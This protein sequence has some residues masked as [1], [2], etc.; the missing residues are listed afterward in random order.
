MGEDSPHA[1]LRSGLVHNAGLA[2][3]G[4]DSGTA[5][6]AARESDPNQVH[7]PREDGKLAAAAFGERTM[8]PTESRIFVDADAVTG[9]S[10]GKA[11]HQAADVGLPQRK[12]LRV[13]EGCARQVTEGSATGQTPVSLPAGEAPPSVEAM[14]SAAR[15]SGVAAAESGSADDGEQLA[16]ALPRT[17]PQSH[18]PEDTL[19]RDRIFRPAGGARPSRPAFLDATVLPTLWGA[20]VLMVHGRKV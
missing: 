14:V 16:D 1:V 13:R 9:S 10:Y 7:V 3:L 20:T 2:P 6:S 11:I 8:P 12:S 15:A 17:L 18:R 5:F 4:A 19:A